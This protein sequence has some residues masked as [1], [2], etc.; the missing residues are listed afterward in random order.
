MSAQ[1][2]LRPPRGVAAKTGSGGAQEAQGADTGTGT[3]AGT[4]AGAAN[5]TRKSGR[6]RK[7][8]RAPLRRNCSLITVQTVPKNK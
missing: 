3:G 8:K 1:I 2:G 7:P 6:A 4:G 5:D